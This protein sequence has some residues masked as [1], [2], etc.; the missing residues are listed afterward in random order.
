[1]NLLPLQRLFLVTALGLGALDVA[2]ASTRAA[3]EEIAAAS[4]LRAAGKHAEALAAF[5]QILARA[6]D[7]PEANHVVS[8]SACDRGEW[9]RALQLAG[10]ALASDPNC[11]RYQYG[12][13]S[14]NGIAALKSG[15]FSKLGHARKCLAAYERAAE[16]EPNNLQYRWAL[17]SYYQQAPGFAGG[18]LEKAYAQAAAMKKIEAEDGRNAFARLYIG[19]K[20]FDRAFREYEEVLRTNPDD[21]PALHS[22]G[23]VALETGQRLDQ[24]IAALQ[25]CL[26]L[27]PPARADVPK[28]D[29]AQWRLGLLWEK[30]KEPA[31]ARA[32]YDAALQLNPAFE[33]A[34]KALAK[35]GAPKP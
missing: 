1:M 34:K 6:P 11:A 30:K 5:E 25:R 7:E 31:K 12:W 26:T 32:A 14:A 17:L 24:G 3:P 20:K 9:E 28:H 4:A 13:A 23:F 2:V 33:P 35:L 27:T 18:D 19:E 8:L 16:L 21:Y 10:K 15:I 29:Y 22:I